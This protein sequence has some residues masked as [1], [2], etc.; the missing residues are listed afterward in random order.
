MED[1]N[2]SE[3][4]PSWEDELTA[5]RQR[6]AQQEQEAAAEAAPSLEGTVQR[7]RWQR[8]LRWTGLALLAALA[9]WAALLGGWWLWEHRPLP[10]PG[11]VKGQVVDLS[12]A[13]VPG[14]VV[15]VEGFDQ[16][17]TISQADGSFVLP[18]V[19]GGTRWIRVELPGH[20]GVTVPVEV[21]SSQEV[22]IGTVA[23]W[24]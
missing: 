6:L 10:P 3:K 8:T 13:P 4:A 22:D 20:A 9:L 16:I 2:R 14:A 1:K 17:R 19:P 24:R 18:G 5:L 12:G 23:L 7:Q 21:P 15:T 11:T